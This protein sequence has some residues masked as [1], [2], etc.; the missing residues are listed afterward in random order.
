MM[1]ESKVEQHLVARVKTLGGEVRKVKW[2]GRRGAPDRLVLFPKSGGHWLV[3]LKRPGLDAEDYQAREH[4]RLRA[5][6][7]TV[8]VLDTVEK[9]DEVFGWPTK[10]RRKKAW[11]VG[12][13]AIPAWA[14]VGLSSGSTIAGTST[15][16]TH[17]HRQR[18]PLYAVGGRQGT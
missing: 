15:A 11:L 17:T 18:L 12:L 5:A 1:R 10:K 16:S 13:S 9:I 14:K 6:G 8:L 4:R 3:E 2:L 7:F